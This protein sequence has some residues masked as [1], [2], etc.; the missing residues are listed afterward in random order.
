MEVDEARQSNH[1][2]ASVGLDLK[3]IEGKVRMA[4]VHGLQH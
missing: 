4:Y 2:D 1:E 3:V